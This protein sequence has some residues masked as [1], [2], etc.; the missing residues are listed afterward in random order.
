MQ[1]EQDFWTEF[2]RAHNEYVAL[3][4]AKGFPFGKYDRNAELPSWVVRNGERPKMN[5]VTRTPEH[6][7]KI[8]IVKPVAKTEVKAAEPKAVAA[9]GLSKAEQVRSMIRDAMANN[10]TIDDV[11]ARAKT[12]LGMGNAQAKTYVTENWTRVSKE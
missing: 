3:R 4:A 9:K 11:I 6:K 1:T 10:K 12:E 8:E 7:P 2:D 5:F